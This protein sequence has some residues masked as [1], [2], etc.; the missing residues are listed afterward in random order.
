MIERLLQRFFFGVLVR[1]VS[2]P[3]ED[4][5]SQGRAYNDRRPSIESAGFSV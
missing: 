4:R 2:E 5:N 1:Q 3:I